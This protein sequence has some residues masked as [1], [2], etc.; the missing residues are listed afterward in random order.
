MSSDLSTLVGAEVVQESKYGSE[1]AHK[2]VAG[3]SFLPRLQLFQ[4]SSGPCKKSKI[5]IGTYAIVRGKDTVVHLLGDDVSAYVVSW[6]PKA[7]RILAGGKLE[8]QYNPKSAK[9][10]KIEVDSSIKD[11][12]CMWGPEYLMYIPA[13][14]EFVTCHFNNPTMRQAASGMLPNVGKA[15]ALRV[16]YIDKGKHSWHGPVPLLSSTP[17]TVPGDPEAFKTE[18]ANQRNKFNN[19]KE[20]EELED[21]VPAEDDNR[22]R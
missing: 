11:S 12:G 22:A 13:V 16:E 8:I 15:I 2:A 18:L 20:E 21:A 6:R 14:N 4:A 5:P 17:L 10:K 9:F 7:I 3:S 19:P 1:V